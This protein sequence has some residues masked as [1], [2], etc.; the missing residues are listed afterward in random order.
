MIVVSVLLS[1]SLIRR[2]TMLLD[3]GTV[4]A[5]LLHFHRTDTVV[6][7]LTHEAMKFSASGL[8]LLDYSLDMTLQMRFQYHYLL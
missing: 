2:D 7:S 1:I 6:T 8:L 3:K 5:F 4:S